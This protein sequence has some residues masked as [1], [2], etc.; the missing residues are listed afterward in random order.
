MCAPLQSFDLSF[1]SIFYLL[2]QILYASRAHFHRHA[3]PAS[4]PL[5]LYF[6]ACAAT[7]Q[8][9]SGSKPS[10][11]IDDLVNYAAELAVLL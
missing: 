6:L 11:L 4:S 2:S 8:S 9:F 1:H 7:M 3:Y 10:H 5:P